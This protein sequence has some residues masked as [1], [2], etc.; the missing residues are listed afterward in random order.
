GGGGQGGV[1]GG[2]GRGAVNGWGRGR[3]TFE[4]EMTSD[5]VGWIGKQLADLPAVLERAGVSDGESFA[6]DAQSLRE[7]SPEI[8]AVLGR[9]LDDVKAGKAAIVPDGDAPESARNSWL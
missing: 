9:L 6:A 8:L 2:G 7:H 5:P 1:E 4:P 3:R